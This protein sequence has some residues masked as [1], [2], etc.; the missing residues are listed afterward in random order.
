ML[1][2]QGKYTKAKV[3][4]DKIES[5]TDNKK[6]ILIFFQGDIGNEKDLITFFN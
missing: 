4:I 1:E 5:A 2:Y 3:M 6:V